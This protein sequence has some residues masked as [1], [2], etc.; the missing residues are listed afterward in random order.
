[1]FKFKKIA[2]SLLLAGLIGLAIWWPIENKWLIRDW[3]VARSYEYSSE[4]LKL[5]DQIELTGTGQRILK[6]SKPV[7]A[8]KSNFKDLCPVNKFEY[9]SVLGCYS[10]ESIYLLEVDDARLDGVEEVTLAHELLHA[11]FERADSSEKDQIVAAVL[12]LNG[13]IEDPEIKETIASYQ[14]TL[15]NQEELA[16][17]MFAIFGTEVKAV[18][19][20]LD[21][22]Y[23]KYF[24]N[25]SKIVDYY[26]KYREVFKKIEAGIKD[27]DAQLAG[28]KAQKNDLEAQLAELD[29]KLN[30]QKAKL[31][32][33]KAEGNFAEFNVEV[34]SYNQMIDS[35]NQTV[36]EIKNLIA[37]YNRLVDSR[38]ALA[39]DS[40]S[41]QEKLDSRVENR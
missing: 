10:K 39:S 18:G 34:Y 38:N 29:T 23:A 32:Q 17:E 35:Y 14:K 24:K 19:A 26:S 31:D 6:A 21:V 7:V 30:E 11:V 37:E 13:Q 25:R 41:L 8:A 2:K 3:W 9:A 16:N 20:E 36:A 4:T 22:I 12:K 27:F 5:K 40:Q 33:L 1:M 28:L 15:T